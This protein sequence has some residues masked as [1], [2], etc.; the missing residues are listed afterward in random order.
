MTDKAKALIRL[1]KADTSYDY[2]QWDNNVSS[3]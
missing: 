3:I 2:Y 1:P